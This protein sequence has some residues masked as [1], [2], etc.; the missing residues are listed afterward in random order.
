MNAYGDGSLLPP[1]LVAVIAKVVEHVQAREPVGV[2]E[3]DEPERVAGGEQA[4][5]GGERER[6][7]T[8][9]VAGVS[10]R[11][12]G[13]RSLRFPLAGLPC[14]ARARRCQRRRQQRRVATSRRPLRCTRG[15]CE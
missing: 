13:R 2:P 12:R 11:A 15:V 7:H 1:L 10:L 14:P 4:A 5:V 3:D 9:A 6:E 8:R